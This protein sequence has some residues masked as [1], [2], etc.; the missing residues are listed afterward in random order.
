MVQSSSKHQNSSEGGPC[1][2]SKHSHLAEPLNGQPALTWRS[3]GQGLTSSA[4]EA[5]AWLSKATHKSGLHIF[6]GTYS[7]HL[8]EPKAG[9]GKLLPCLCHKSL[10]NLCGHLGIWEAHAVS[11]FLR[12][13]RTWQQGRI[14]ESSTVLYLQSRLL[15]GLD[16]P[17]HVPHQPC[18]TRRPTIAERHCTF[19]MPFCIRALSRLVRLKW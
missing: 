8:A 16:T 12:P 2:Q 5:V 6:L 13:A 7:A 18:N 17:K 1:I 4:N 14:P 11:A 10:V 19:S 9:S 3:F 15:L